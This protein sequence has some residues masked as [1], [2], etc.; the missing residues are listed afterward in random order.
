M[1]T[2]PPCDGTTAVLRPVFGKM[3][4]RWTGNTQMEAAYELRLI[5]A[6]AA[7]ATDNLAEAARYFSNCPTN[8]DIRG[9]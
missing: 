1:T 6:R 4:Y 5:M 9:L 8:F 3:A 7:V 2:C